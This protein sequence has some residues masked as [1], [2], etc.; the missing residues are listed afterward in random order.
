MLNK[1][2]QLKWVMCEEIEEGW[3]KTNLLYR[4]IKDS[5]AHNMTTLIYAAT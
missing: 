4:T 5:T 3:A 1:V 2:I